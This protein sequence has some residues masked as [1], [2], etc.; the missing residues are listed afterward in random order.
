M[1][2]TTK[3]AVIATLHCL[4]GCA[5]G[6]VL[7]MV[8]GTALNF[9]DGVTIGLS[10][11]LAFVFGYSFSIVPILRSGLTPRQ[12][13]KVTLAGDTVSITSMEIVDNLVIILIPGALVAGLTSGLFWGSLVISLIIAFIVTVPVNRYLIARGK[14]HAVMHKYHE[15]SS[16]HHHH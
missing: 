10:I 2:E 1:N 9:H 12:A 5:I 15:H 14:G 3:S 16:E 7:G 4:L 11:A 13:I 8:I 6:E